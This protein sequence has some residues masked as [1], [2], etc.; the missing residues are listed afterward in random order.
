MKDHPGIPD[1]EEYL[2]CQIHPSDLWNTKTGRRVLTCVYEDY[3]FELADW[4]VFITLTFREETYLETAKKRFY[5]LVRVLNEDAFGKRYRRF[6]KHSYFSYVLATEYQLRDVIH[7]HFLADRPLNFQL[8][9]DWWQEKAGFAHTDIIKNREKAVYYVVKYVV[10]GGE[11]EFY[12]RESDRLPHVMPSW[13]KEP[14]YDDMGK[15]AA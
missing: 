4:Q 5:K 7:F 1:F 14:E 10:K 12:E 6:V 8:I 11:P 3:L 9:H 13:W 2:D 15:R